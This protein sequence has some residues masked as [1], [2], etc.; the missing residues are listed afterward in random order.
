MAEESP[1]RTL[2][3]GFVLLWGRPGTG[4]S[5]LL[6]R[7][8]GEPIAI[9]CG[10]PRTSRHRIVGVREEDG[11]QMIFVDVPGIAPA[12]DLLERSLQK[13]AKAE[14]EAADAVLFLVDGRVNPSGDDHYASHELPAVG[15]PVILVVNKI[16]EE[17]GGPDLDAR[18]A[19]YAALRPFAA[20]A[21]ISAEGEEGIDAL[22]AEVRSRLPEGPQYYPEGTVTDIPEKLEIAER[23]REQCLLLLD[24]EVPHSCVVMVRS[25]AERVEG[26]LHVTATIHVEKPSQKAIVV[27]KGGEMVKRIGTAARK[28]L[29]AIL[30]KRVYLVLEVAV[31]PRW[32]RDALALK[33]F[34]Y[35]VEQG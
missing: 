7:L 3:S 29:E 17:E 25:L 35:A 24:K 11:F 4:K 19:D 21:R 27:G 2:R 10:K 33:R 34:G 30:G 18:V 6:G 26:L 9:A 20:V 16:E 12:K 32:R 5:T 15:A 22:L 14:I 13:T 8:V 31:A 23:I 1:E 28:S